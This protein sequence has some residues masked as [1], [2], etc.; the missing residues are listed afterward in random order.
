MLRQFDF[1]P[2]N[3]EVPAANTTPKITI[4]PLRRPSIGSVRISHPK[5]GRGPQVI[6][7]IGGVTLDTNTVGTRGMQ[8]WI[9]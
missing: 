4:T 7:K 1:T 5:F 3:K 2:D 9:A 8:T 6:R